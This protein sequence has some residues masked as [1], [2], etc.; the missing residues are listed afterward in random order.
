MIHPSTSLVWPGHVGRAGP[1]A[2]AGRAD[3]QLTAKVRRKY[4]DYGIQDKPFV[5]LK[6][7]VGTNVGVMTVR[8][9]KEIAGLNERCRGCLSLGPAGRVFRD[10]LVQEGVPT[11]E[12]VHDAVAEP[13]VYTMD[14]YVGGLLPRA[15]PARRGRK[16]QRARLQLRAPGLHR[17]PT[18]DPSG[19][20]P[21]A[22]VPNRFYMYGVVARLALLAAAYEL[23]ATDPLAETL[24][25]A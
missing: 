3:A 1:G 2:T 21:G 8:D 17:G 16:P 12:R 5:V 7:D 9:P 22:S 24:E 14:R 18:A 19:E 6:S 20:R 25:T 10:F 23:E 4:K 13:V 15:C 11:F